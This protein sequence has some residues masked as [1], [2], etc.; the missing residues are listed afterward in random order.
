MYLNGEH[1]NQLEDEIEE[2][3]N[4]ENHEKSE[5]SF[6]GFLLFDIIFFHIALLSIFDVVRSPWV[7]FCV[8]DIRNAGQ[9]HQKTIEPN[10][11]T[12]MFTTTVTSSIQVPI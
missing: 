3:K 6:L 1:Y 4:I 2:K 10:A 7:W 11:E 12:G 9:I 5:Y 8:A